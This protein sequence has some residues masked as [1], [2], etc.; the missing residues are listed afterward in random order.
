[1]GLACRQGYLVLK[2]GPVL[3][4]LICLSFLNR[5]VGSKVIVHIG[6]NSMFIRLSL[7]KNIRGLSRS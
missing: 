6:L 1:M 7:F 3:W 4:A 5:G 2:L